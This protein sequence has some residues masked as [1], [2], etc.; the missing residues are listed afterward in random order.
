MVGSCFLISGHYGS[1]RM[2][3]WSLENSRWSFTPRNP[4][5]D[6]CAPLFAWRCLYLKMFFRVQELLLLRRDLP[7]RPEIKS[8]K[9]AQNSRC[10]VA[11]Q[12]SF[13]DLSTGTCFAFLHSNKK[14]GVSDNKKKATKYE[15][16]VPNVFDINYYE[17]SYIKDS[18]M[19]ER[20]DNLL[21]NGI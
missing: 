9:P 19:S 15:A 17:K 8:L 10:S 7:G 5:R 4:C 21:S 20:G 2:L 16:S 11:K 18:R 13:H 3:W 12:S 14:R 6:N 1:S